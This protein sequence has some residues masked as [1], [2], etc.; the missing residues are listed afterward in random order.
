M[1]LPAETALGQQAHVLTVLV[2]VTLPIAWIHGRGPERKIAAAATLVIGL[3]LLRQKFLAG[4]GDMASFRLDH[5]LL[6]L[7]VLTSLGAIALRANRLY[8]LVMTGAALIAVLAHGLRWL[9]LLSGQLSYFVLITAPAF[10]MVAAYWTGLALHIRRV[11]R[12]GSY[13]DWRGTDSTANDCEPARDG[14]A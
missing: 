3:D 4:W 9:G 6:D 10:V 1:T 2:L 13:P 14:V 5:A 11:R 8:P 12:F 7:L